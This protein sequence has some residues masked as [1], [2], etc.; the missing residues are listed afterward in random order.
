MA[1]L[2]EFVS[3]RAVECLNQKTDWGNALKQGLRDQEGLVLGASPFA[4]VRLRRR[5]HTD[6]S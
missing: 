6:A 5:R 2:L 4:V 1:D 3:L